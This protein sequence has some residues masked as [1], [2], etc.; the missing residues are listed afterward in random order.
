MDALVREGLDITDDPNEEEYDLLHV[1][2]PLP[3]T[4]ILEIRKAKKRGIPVVMHSHTTA[5]DAKGTWTGSS[6][7]SGVVGRYLTFFYNHGDVVIAPSSWTRDTL[8]ARHVKTRI[9]VLSNGIDLERFRL[10][11]E[12]RKRF[13]ERY[14]IPEGA[15]VVYSVGVVCIKKGV[16]ALPQVAQEVSDLQFVWVGRRSKLYHPIH[17]NHIIGKCPSNVRFLNDV[18][19]ILDAHC[20]CDIFFTPSFTE[21]QGLALMEAMAVGR[22]VVA[23]NL[24]VYQNLLTDGGNA[25]MCGTTGE[26]AA[27]IE[28]LRCD[29]ELSKMFVERGKDAL[30]RH[31]I[32]KVAKD[33]V[34]I[35]SS[36]LETYPHSYPGR[37]DAAKCTLDM[38]KGQ[39]P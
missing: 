26:F 11:L 27:S 28:K 15:M 1:H 36:L 21:N 19:D 8:R 6:T 37:A 5:E 20:G 34:S 3:F 39:L 22:P 2:T 25:F 17:I 33:L 24:P 18:E 13:R 29:P 16:E 35:Y 12:R 23:R 9:E 38:A 7:L 30:Q 10:D 32:G 14:E 31:E 4:N